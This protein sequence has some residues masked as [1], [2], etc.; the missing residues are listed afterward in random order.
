LAQYSANAGKKASVGITS[1]ASDA[2]GSTYFTDICGQHDCVLEAHR[3]HLDINAPPTLQYM[4]KGFATTSGFKT[5]PLQGEEN[6][7]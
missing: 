2:T 5:A 1:M 3:L 4:C 6:E 7:K